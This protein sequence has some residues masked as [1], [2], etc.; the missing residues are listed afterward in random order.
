MDNPKLW[1]AHSEKDLEYVRSFTD[2]LDRA[3]TGFDILNLMAGWSSADVT[4]AIETSDVVIAVL[5]S[6]MDIQELIKQLRIASTYSK[7]VNVIVRKEDISDLEPTLQVLELGRLLA[8][9]FG[10]LTEPSKFSGIHP[11]DI[12]YYA[13]SRGTTGPF[14]V[15]ISRRSTDAGL[16]T[17]IHD[18]LVSNGRRAFVANISITPGGNSDFTTQIERAL[19][20]SEHFLLV[21]SSPGSLSSGWVDAEWRVFLNEKNS[22]RKTGNLVIV[23]SEEDFPIDQLPGLLRTS[24]VLTWR[25]VTTGAPL[26]D[27][28]PVVERSPGT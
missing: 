19:L 10:Q 27:L 9:S 23:V 11:A 22:G 26:L 20:Q 6:G 13:K 3:F 17:E 18:Y 4:N 24:Q 14:D 7:P 15:F 2:W 28:L 1:I 8:R 5:S 16:A 21:L 25:G 12:M